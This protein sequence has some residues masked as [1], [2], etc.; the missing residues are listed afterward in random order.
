[1][2]HEKPHPHLSFGIG[3]ALIACFFLA[4]ASSLVWYFQG[5]F[6]TIQ[7]IFIQNVVSFFCILPLALRNGWERLKTEHLE[8]HFIRDLFGVASYYLFFL[9]IRYL[10]L[11]DAT[12]L[13]YTAPFFVPFIWWVW[14]REKVEPRVWWTIIIGFIGVAIILNPTSDI[15]QLGFVFGLT[16]GVASAIGLS[17][18]R[19]L[20][21]KREPMTRT[22]FYYFSLG[23][24]LSFP[25]A[26]AVWVPP[27][28]KEWLLAASIGVA[29]AVGQILLTIAYRYGTASF[30]SPLGYSVV[31]YN[32]LI[33]YFIYQ[34]ELG[35]RSLLGTCLIVVGGSLTYILKEKPHSIKETFEAPKTKEKPPL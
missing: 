24:L 21:I 22:L 33:S 1:M 23:S 13:N 34:K 29:T 6:P 20:N 11:V 17:A 5:R 8:T 12:T 4:I 35:W 14:M 10:N 32:G 9:A 3:T 16:A 18:L 25:F 7:I 19:V 30:L 27:S 2:S 28:G 26:W 15:F 31:V